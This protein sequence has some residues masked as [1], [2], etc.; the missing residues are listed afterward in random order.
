M[1]TML[2]CALFLVGCAM[3]YAKLSDDLSV[4]QVAWRSGMFYRVETSVRNTSDD[5]LDLKVVCTTD[6]REK[7]HNIKVMPRS[8]VMLTEKVM[9]PLAG[10]VSAGCEFWRR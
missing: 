9:R 6:G 2:I 4:R 3:P 8:E 10:G 5:R 7:V 1:R